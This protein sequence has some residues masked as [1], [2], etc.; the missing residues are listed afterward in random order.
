MRSMHLT[1]EDAFASQIPPQPTTMTTIKKKGSPVKVN[2]SPRKVNSS[3]HKVNR[4]AASSNSKKG[5]APAHKS[6][7]VMFI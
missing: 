7:K 4:S 1:V 2:S 5:K 6:R 3:P